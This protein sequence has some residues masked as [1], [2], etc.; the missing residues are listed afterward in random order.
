MKTNV[1]VMSLEQAQAAADKLA[2]TQKSVRNEADIFKSF[3]EFLLEKQPRE[4]FNLPR[5]KVEYIPPAILKRFLMLYM[6]NKSSDLAPTE[7]FVPP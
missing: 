5:G 7:K 4:I 6:P 3:L 1:G 2:S